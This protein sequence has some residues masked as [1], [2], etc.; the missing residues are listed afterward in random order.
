MFRWSAKDGRWPVR[1]D[2]A[3][4]GAAEGGQLSTPMVV[5]Q[6]TKVRTSRF[7]EQGVRP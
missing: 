5:I 6:Y 2:G 3:P 7:L 4:A 1:M